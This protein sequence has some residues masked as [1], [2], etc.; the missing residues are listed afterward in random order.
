MAGEKMMKQK[1][2]DEVW[3]RIVSQEFTRLVSRS[4]KSPFNSALIFNL[5]ELEDN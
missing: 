4:S 2:W 3:E 5:K 1:I